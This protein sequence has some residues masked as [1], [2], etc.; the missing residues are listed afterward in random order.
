MAQQTLTFLLIRS[1]G[2]LHRSTSQEDNPNQNKSSERKPALQAT[3]NRN[4]SKNENNLN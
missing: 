2:V 3:T 4:F 1:K